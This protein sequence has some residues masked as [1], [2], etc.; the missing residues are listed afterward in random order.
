[1]AFDLE[2]RKNLFKLKSSINIR[3]CE[4]S[5][6]HLPT[7]TRGKTMQSVNYTTVTY[8]IKNTF[9]SG[10]MISFADLKE[11][12]INVEVTQLDKKMFVRLS[13]QLEMV[14]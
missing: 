8:T 14:N 1:M 9:I 5:T 4:H 3:R 7:Q 11:T 12:G 13:R 6:I 2:K 10:K